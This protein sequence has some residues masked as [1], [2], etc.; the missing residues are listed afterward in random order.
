MVHTQKGKINIS[1]FSVYKKYYIMDKNK[2]NKS[3]IKI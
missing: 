1:P 2:E 3:L